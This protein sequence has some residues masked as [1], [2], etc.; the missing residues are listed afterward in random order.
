MNSVFAL[1]FTQLLAY[2]AYRSRV[3]QIASNNS[4]QHSGTVLPPP[5]D[6]FSNSI[7]ASSRY[8]I[9]SASNV[10]SNALIVT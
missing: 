1:P 9:R 4:Q 7:T 10:N 5:A 8:H 6:D 2:C 3:R